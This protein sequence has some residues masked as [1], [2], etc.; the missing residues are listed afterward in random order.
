MIF[1]DNRFRTGEE[2][3]SNQSEDLRPMRHLDYPLRQKHTK[4]VLSVRP[5][6][7]GSHGREARIKSIY[8]HVEFSVA[9]IR[10]PPPDNRWA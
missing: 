6:R 4:K 1:V 2:A 5:D 7:V 9:K 3:K 10:G 8:G